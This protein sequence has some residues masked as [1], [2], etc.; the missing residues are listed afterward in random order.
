VRLDGRAEP[1]A[2]HDQRCLRV[3]R[4]HHASAATER[5]AHAGDAVKPM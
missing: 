4:A 5:D 1:F 2:T 3:A